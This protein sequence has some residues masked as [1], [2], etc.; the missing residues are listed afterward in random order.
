MSDNMKL[1][2]YYC[3]IPFGV[4]EKTKS[5][6][7]YTSYTANEQILLTQGLLDY[8]EY[9]L[10]NSSKR[11][12]KT[13]FPDMVQVITECSR[14]DILERAGI[15]PQ[16]SRWEKLVKLARLKFFPRGFYVQPTGD[17]EEES[18]YHL[19]YHENVAGD[20]RKDDKDWKD[21]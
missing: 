11:E 21:R 20:S 16:D 12:S 2:Y 3:S 15:R 10:W 18:N 17:M 5:G 6:Y 8:S 14:R 4:L 13:L 1:T 9:G 19:T 7:S